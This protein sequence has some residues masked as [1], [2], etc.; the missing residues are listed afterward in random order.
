M[1]EN[2]VLKNG[3]QVIDMRNVEKAFDHVSG[4]ILVPFQPLAQA[5]CVSYRKFAP[6]FI[7]EKSYRALKL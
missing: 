5:L 3:G 1:G 7:V 4:H 2:A 6:E